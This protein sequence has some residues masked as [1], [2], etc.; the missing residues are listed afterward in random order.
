MTSTA[1]YPELYA[2]TEVSK[3]ESTD[4]ECSCD[5]HGQRTYK[6]NLIKFKTE[7]CKNYS[8][9]GYCP[10]RSKCQF[11]HGQHE[12]VQTAKNVKKAYRTKKCKSFWEEGTCRYGFR[13]QFL[14][15]ETEL[16]KQKDFLATAKNMLCV[17]PVGGRSRLTSLF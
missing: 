11:A 8:E 4:D 16:D 17:A 6:T 1:L 14:H 10:Y 13:C 7:I 3:A 15:Y 12:L 9:M 5:S 2:Y